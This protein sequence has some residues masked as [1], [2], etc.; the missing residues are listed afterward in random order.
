MATS[1]KSLGVIKSAPSR[2][3]LRSMRALRILYWILGIFAALV[4]IAV[5]VIAA[6]DWNRLKPTINERASAALERPFA[7]NGDMSVHWGRAEGLSGWRSWLPSP[8]I[9]A[10]DI[11]IGNPDWVAGKAEK[12]SVGE[13]KKSKRDGFAKV[14]EAEVA[15]RLLP[16]LG[17]HLSVPYV[18]LNGPTVNLLRRD[19]KHANWNFGSDGEPSSWSVDLGELRIAKAK[20]D[21]DDEV[22]DADFAITIDPLDD[23]IPFSDLVG[24]DSRNEKDEK[25]KPSEVQAFAYA[26]TAKG[27]YRGAP[28]DGSGKLGSVLTLHEGRQ[29]FPLQADARLGG[30]RVRLTGTLTDPTDL[31]GLDLRL[32][33]SG[34]SMAQLYPYAGI[35]LP[36]TPP[37]STSGHLTARIQSDDSRFHYENFVGK[38][39]DSDLAGTVTFT[40]GGDRPKLE[41][42]LRSEQLRLA[43]LGPVVGADTSDKPSATG[44]AHSND[45]LLPEDRFR[46]DR[47]NAMD[48]DVTFEGKKI[49]QDAGLPISGL[50]THVVMSNAKLTLDPLGVGL[51]NGK[52]SGKIELD[53]RKEPL[54]GKIDLNAR[55]LGLKQLFPKVELMQESAGQINGN[56]DIAATGQ[57]V[58]ALLA[59]SNG[60][61]KLLMDDGTISKE[62]LET[63]GLNVANIVIS[64][65]FGDKP[66]RIDCAAA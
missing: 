64:K 62:L 39:G 25:T 46:T 18:R 13:K 14:D 22:T 57:S 47:W 19:A 58:A 28:I 40:T 52:L 48:A 41:G 37:F 51:A 4:L 53:A 12:K 1:S 30:V 66:I 36:D 5:I 27:T 17:K 31:S 3:Q 8:V 32:R 15:L 55:D 29:P 33:L 45:K 23:A 10:S 6:F 34:G 20:I 24:D 38:V 26:W 49:V 44:D 11:E 54:R 43:D 2:K 56:I 59:S 35:T 9:R 65:L 21:V 42:T 61:L 16:L 7:I 63:A 60:E 50:S